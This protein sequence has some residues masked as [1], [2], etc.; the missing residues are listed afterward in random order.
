ML[1]QSPGTTIKPERSAGTAR[2]RF[3]TAQRTALAGEATVFYPQ[4]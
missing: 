2:L 3:R 4:K 1:A